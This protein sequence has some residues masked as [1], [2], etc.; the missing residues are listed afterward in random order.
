M[1]SRRPSGTARTSCGACGKAS[2]DGK[3]PGTTSSNITEYDKQVEVTAYA[4]PLPLKKAPVAA[5][6]LEQVIETRRRIRAGEATLTSHA[7]FVGGQSASTMNFD[8]AGH[9]TR[10]RCVFYDLAME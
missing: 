6:D 4:L 3:S 10:L 7:I 2:S 8:V 1:T 5:R 9:R